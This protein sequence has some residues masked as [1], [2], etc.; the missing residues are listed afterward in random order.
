MYQSYAVRPA[1]NKTLFNPG[2]YFDQVA[3]VD[4]NA[5]LDFVGQFYPTVAGLFR[6][7]YLRESLASRCLL[8]CPYGP[9]LEH[10]PFFEDASPIVASL[11]RFVTT[12]VNAYYTRKS[13]NLKNDT[14][15]Q[16]WILEANT[17]AKVLDFPPAPL[18]E[19]ETLIDILT[20]MAYL[21]GVNHHLLNSNA[22]SY[23]TGLLPFHP[24]AFFQ[25]LPTSKGVSNITH[26]LA[27]LEHAMYQVTLQLRF[28]R[29][30]LPDEH[31]ELVDMFSQGSFDSDSSG[32]LPPEVVEA[33]KTF[34]SEMEGIGKN[35]SS[36]NF[37]ENGLSQGMPFVWKVLD[38]TKIPYF[39]CV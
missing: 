36:K 24:S 28:Q 21:T 16:A 19:I 1:G 4:Q 39:L 6:S 32:M 12:F 8:D 15:V 31:R 9:K 33:A 20:Q 35:V 26:Y 37:D 29:P 18:N 25:P 13:D 38:P 5:V 23:I 17:K 2:G 27:D 14:E 3:A 22:P 10:L 7:N 11:R 30:Q 34:R